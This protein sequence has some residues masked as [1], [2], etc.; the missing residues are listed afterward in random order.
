MSTNGKAF[1]D[2][3]TASATD[4]ACTGRFDGGD[5]RTSFFRF[6]RKHLPEHAQ[7][8]V[9]GGEGQV[10][11]VSHEREGQVLNS[12]IAVGVD[13]P[14]RGLMPELAPGVGDVLMQNG[15]LSGRLAPVRAA[16][17]ATG[18]PTL[19]HAQVGEVL[20]QPA[21]VIDDYPVGQ[22]QQVIQTYIDAD[23]RSA[24]LNRP[25]VGQ[26]QHQADVP[27][28]ERPL[29]NDMF[30]Y[31]VGWYVPVQEDLD[32]ADVLNVETV[33]RKLAPV[34]IP[35]LHRLETF[36]V[37]ETGMSGAARVERLVCLIDTAKHLLDRRG[38]EHTH[39][40]GQSV[41]LAADA[42]PLLDVSY[43]LARPLPLDAALIERVIVDGL[44]LAKKAIQKM[45]LFLGWAKPVLEGAD[46]AKGK[47]VRLHLFGCDTQTG[48]AGRPIH[49][50]IRLCVAR[51]IVARL[52]VS[53]KAIAPSAAHIQLS[54]LVESAS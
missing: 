14:A 48:Q 34:T 13:Y 33:G 21:G 27:L 15:H 5:L 47:T 31:R 8:R 30:G 20:S 12:D 45:R 28:A 46:H 22:G 36:D 41:A 35:V 52:F 32:A 10:A 51:Q 9:V 7:S 2:N 23:V 24:G 29:H 38:V 16:L 43:R 50:R 11:V 4:L 40:I 18:H 39:L 1:N 44:H 26:F 17:L 54:A 25:S 42:V 49:Y 6:V 37:L 3:R 53:S 19:R